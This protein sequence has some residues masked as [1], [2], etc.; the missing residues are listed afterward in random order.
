MIFR[1][2]RLNV[3]TRWI[4]P[5]GSAAATVQTPEPPYHEGNA[6][7]NDRPEDERRDDDPGTRTAADHSY[8]EPD[9]QSTTA[10]SRD[11]PRDTPLA[12]ERDREPWVYD[13]PM[14]RDQIDAIPEAPATSAGTLQAEAP[15]ARAEEPDPLERPLDEEFAPL[16][17][18]S[19]P[20]VVATPSWMSVNDDSPTRQ[21][22]PP[23]AVRTE[24]ETAGRQAEFSSERF[25]DDDLAEPVTDSSGERLIHVDN[26]RDPSAATASHSHSDDD[27]PGGGGGLLENTESAVDSAR[28][29]ITA[30]ASALTDRENVV[31]DEIGTDFLHIED[32]RAE[33]T[34]STTDPIGEAVDA[35]DS[36]P[37]PPQEDD[38][39]PSRGG[40]FLGGIGAAVGSAREALTSRASTQAESGS[41]TDT[42]TDGGP[43]HGGP[44]TETTPNES[45]M[46][47]VLGRLRGEP[48]D[49]LDPTLQAA[50]AVPQ[51]MVLIGGAI[52]IFMALLS[53]NAGLALIVASAIVPVSIALAL[54]QRDLFEKESTLAVSAAGGAGLVIG[55]IL[56]LVSSWIVSSSWFSYGTLNYGA[57][58]FGG[59]FANLA[60]S[61]PFSVWLLSGLLLP[62]VGL[63]AI[64]A[65]PFAMRRWPQFRN[66]VMDGVILCGTSAAGFA[67]G[68]AIVYWAPMVSGRGPQTDVAD[69][70]LTALG[71]ALLRPIVITLAGA[72]LGAGIWKY[73]SSAH[74]ASLLLPA[75]G[76]I[77]GILLLSFGSLQF[78]PSGLWPEAVWTGLVAIASFMIYRLV[79]NAAISADRAVIGEN[80]TRVVCPSCRK[81]TPAGAFC[82]HCGSTLE[83]VPAPAPTV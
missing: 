17:R 5:Q 51:R 30:R 42:R 46:G 9:R 14:D 60:G 72:M 10:S 2:R 20:D 64:V 26:A 62:L 78:G 63:A 31:R 66:E 56:G 1:G 81:I 12:D 68:S 19:G 25:Y 80:R 6:V 16:P 21:L 75:V 28:E 77:G 38:A 61:V 37:A 7:M 82:A 52:G 3:P 40:G 13:S 15:D 83:Q 73:M 70:T 24:A 11:T 27:A 49:L 8:N 23:D 50:T 59:R 58:G 53:N 57:A 45:R 35:S 33:A 36:P 67:I 41:E 34:T 65:V 29:V 55:V 32:R 79:L 69:W 44:E 74:P 47:G 48:G 54:N 22:T 39:T 4:A 71:V 76:S 18:A 43:D